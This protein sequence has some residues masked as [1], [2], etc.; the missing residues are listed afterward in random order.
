M[1]IYSKH[2]NATDQIYSVLVLDSVNI[3]DD[4]EYFCRAF[5][6]PLCYAE[7]KTR[8]TVECKFIAMPASVIY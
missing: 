7:R 1:T 3:T 6:D 2:D 8:L 4:G 5:N